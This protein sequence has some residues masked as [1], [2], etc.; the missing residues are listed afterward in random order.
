MD[1]AI[2]LGIQRAIHFAHAAAPDQRQDLVFLIWLREGGPCEY[3]TVIRRSARPRVTGG[4]EKAAQS[5]RAL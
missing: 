5:A 2:K 1:L 4:A 3:R